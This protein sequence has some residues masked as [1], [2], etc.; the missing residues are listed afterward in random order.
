MSRDLGKR[1]ASHVQTA[2]AR[3]AQA[4]AGD[5]RQRVVAPH[6]QAAIA[7]GAQAKI[8]DG[9]RPVAR[10]RQAPQGQTLAAHVEASVLG[11]AIAQPKKG[12]LGTEGREVA[13]HVQV[14]LKSS[15]TAQRRRE[16]PGGNGVRST[17][18][19][20]KQMLITDYFSGGGGNSGGNKQNSNK[21][22]S[23]SSKQE[24]QV[25]VR[26]VLVFTADSD[27]GVGDFDYN[28]YNLYVDDIQVHPVPLPLHATLINIINPNSL[29]TL[30][31]HINSTTDII[32]QQ[33]RIQ[34]TNA[35]GVHYNTN[36]VA[37][38]DEIDDV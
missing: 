21:Q 7:V 3:G 27:I 36:A 9:R 12:G 16:G 1:P 34:L 18:Q 38:E 15:S 6:V 30:C 33:K 31:S 13:S 2:I 5:G 37:I 24:K 23:S 29:P 11:G 17:I 19:R 14:A 32:G 8:A 26:L 35:L 25:S 22:I 20:S 10:Q 28:E 4:K